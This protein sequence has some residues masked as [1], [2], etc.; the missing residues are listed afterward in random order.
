MLRIYAAV[1]VAP[2]YMR[3]FHQQRGQEHPLNFP[4]VSGQVVL[5]LY[6]YAAK[7][8]LNTQQRRDSFWNTCKGGKLKKLFCASD[9]WGS[10]IKFGTGYA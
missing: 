6:C 1:G 3:W 2:C 4:E 10:R 5:L 9:A 7:L 8:S